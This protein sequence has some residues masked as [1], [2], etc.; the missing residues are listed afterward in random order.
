MNL[1]DTLTQDLLHL[2]LVLDLCIR[3]GKRSCPIS[4]LHII[5][6]EVGVGK[7]FA[8]IAD[9]GIVFLLLLSERDEG[10]EA[11]VVGILHAKHAEES[12]EATEGSLVEGG[13]AV[14]FVDHLALEV[15]QH[16]LYLHL[17]GHLTHD[18]GQSLGVLSRVNERLGEW[19][20]DVAEEN[21]AQGAVGGEGL[22]LA[23]ENGFGHIV[24][25]VALVRGGQCLQVLHEELRVAVAGFPALLKV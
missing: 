18:G 16:V 22:F 14:G 11:I 3:V 13:S 2:I 19:V 10:G 1:I 17:H 7:I 23:F 4:Q 12:L 5:G 15:A 9:V 6:I 20:V 24:S 8:D 25:F 21:H